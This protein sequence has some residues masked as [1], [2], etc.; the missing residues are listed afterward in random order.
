MLH[1][2][3]GILKTLGFCA[4]VLF[5]LLCSL[6]PVP[7]YA[8]ALSGTS[9]VNSESL[10]QASCTDT[11]RRLRVL[12]DEL[13]EF[14][15]DLRI[16]N[17]SEQIFNGT[18]CVDPARIGH[19]WVADGSMPS[20]LALVLRDGA[21]EVDRVEVILG[22]DGEDATCPDVDDGG[23]VD[24]PVDPEDPG[25]D[26][27]EVRGP[28]PVCGPATGCAAGYGLVGGSTN[29]CTVGTFAAFG[30]D[31]CGAGCCWTCSSG[32]ETTRCTK[33]TT[34]CFIAGTQV[35]LIDGTQKPIEQVVVGD[36]VLGM[37]EKHNTV[38]EVLTHDI[39]E[40]KLYAFN[41]GDY[42]VTA[43][44]PFMTTDGWKAIDPAQTEMRN[45]KFIRE[46]GTPT[47]LEKG[48]VLILEGGKTMKIKRIEGRD[49]Y[50]NDMP[51]YNL[52]VDGNH[53]YYANHYLVHN[54]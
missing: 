33:G 19:E 20:G 42:F 46:N 9:G 38:Q 40:Q 22:R 53:T 23:S 4:L 8:Q 52:R 34:T 39:Q 29:A 30:G 5:V 2:L 12:V 26:D 24:P 27:E 25:D 21:T 11:V 44:H 13:E 51:V 48:D 7:S 43:E 15:E 28:A 37:D 16:C 45:P 35:T 6:G 1:P 10:R 36:V 47:Y 18:A 17:E 14:A 3:S 41:G 31:W 49:R 32:G 54:K 50:P